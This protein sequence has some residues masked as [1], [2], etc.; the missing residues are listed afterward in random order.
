[1]NR[2]VILHTVGQIIKLEAALLCL[3]LLVGLYYKNWIDVHA[4]GVTALIALAIGL[5]L[6]ITCRRGDR[7]IFA[8]GGLVSVALSWISLSLIGALPFVF[9]GAIPSYIDALFET[10]S[11]LTTTGASILETPEVLTRGML[12]WRSFTHWIGGMGVI[13][14]MMAILPAESGRSIHIMRAEMPGPIIGKLV[15]RLRDTAKVLYLIYIALTVM[16]IVLLLVGGMPLFD[17]VVHTFG[18]AGTGGFGIKADSI[19]GYSAYSQWVIAIFMLIFGVNFNVYQLILMRRFRTALRS[20]ELWFYLGLVAVAATVIAI[21]VAPQF[22]TVEEAAR[23]AVFQ[24]ASIS[25]TTGYATADFNLWPGIARTVLLVLMFVGACAGSTAGGLKI[26]RV[27]LLFKSIKRDLRRIM[28]PRSVGC[29]TLEGKKVDETTLTGVSAYFAL[30]ILCIAAAFVCL[31]FEPFDLETNFSAVVACFNNVG[32]GLGA[33]G[34]T[35]NYGDYS[36]VSKLILSLAM[37]LGRLEIYPLLVVL[38]PST[39]QKKR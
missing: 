11:G 5:L 7:H 3:P 31:S 13:V 27:M 12:F 17:S 16:Q 2:R 9:S 6:T 25:T 4:F 8:R 10:V 34:P 21:A 38:S 20:G 39:W 28:H 15:P 18:T 24:V 30:Y 19:G 36:V 22:E 14:L 26:S 35:G 29:V 23:H 37:L 33:V 1:M 32:P